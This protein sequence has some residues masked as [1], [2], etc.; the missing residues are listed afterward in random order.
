MSV[1]LPNPQDWVARLQINLPELALVGLWPALDQAINAGLTLSP[2]ACVIPVTEIADGNTRTTHGVSQ[3]IQA[4]WAVLLGVRSLQDVS[5]AA[6]N[7]QLRRLRQAIM[8]ILLDWDG[9]NT[10]ITYRGG[11]PG[12][13]ER[14]ALWW[15]DEYTFAY[16]LR[17]V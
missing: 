8:E 11:R 17:V 7:D 12:A 13:L 5:G 16:H 6:Q 10:Q 9:V 1:L 15:V 2:M 3:L 14:G 4:T